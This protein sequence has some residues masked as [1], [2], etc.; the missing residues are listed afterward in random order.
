M[1]IQL[2]FSYTAV[3][4]KMAKESF[5]GPRVVLHVFLQC[6]SCEVGFTTCVTNKF[7]PGPGV[8]G[9]DV[10]SQDTLTFKGSATCFTDTGQAR[11]DSGLVFR[12]FVRDDGLKLT[13]LFLTLINGI[14]GFVICNSML[15]KFMFHKSDMIVGFSITYITHK[16]LLFVV[17]WVDFP[18]VLRERLHVLEDHLTLPAVDPLLHLLP[19]REKLLVPLYSLRN[20]AIR[21][22][23]LADFF[24]MDRV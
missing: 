18:P 23:L 6:L 1:V 21:V 9:L 19:H 15:L 2:L 13:V 12:Q 16:S 24:S 11:V 14:L 3:R 4:T 10:V 8:I 17:R 7:G 5:L 22:K 20:G